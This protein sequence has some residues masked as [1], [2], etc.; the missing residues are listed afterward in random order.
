MIKISSHEL[1][2]VKQ[3]ID[4]QIEVDGIIL[5]WEDIY[6]QLPLTI[7]YESAPWEIDAFSRAKNLEKEMEEVL[8]FKN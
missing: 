8:L 1:I 2:H 5:R 4:K 7:T 3:Y 6:Y